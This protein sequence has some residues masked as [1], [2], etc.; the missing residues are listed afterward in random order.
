MVGATLGVG[1]GVGIGA[2]IGVGKLFAK[3]LIISGWCKRCQQT[4]VL[5]VGSVLGVIAMGLIGV[6]EQ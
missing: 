1:I 6:R 4:A 5:H 3:L 2:T